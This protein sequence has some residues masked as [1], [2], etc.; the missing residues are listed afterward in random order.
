MKKRYKMLKQIQ[1]IIIPM[2]MIMPYHLVQAEDPRRSGLSSEVLDKA[3][4][5]QLP[6]GMKLPSHLDESIPNKIELKPNEYTSQFLKYFHIEIQSHTALTNN[7]RKALD[8]TRSYFGLTIGN[9]IN[10]VLSDP[11]VYSKD[12]KFYIGLNV[13]AS[14]APVMLKNSVKKEVKHEVM[15]KVREGAST[16]AAAKVLQAFEAQVKPGIGAGLITEAEYQAMLY[17]NVEQTVQAVSNNES[18]IKSLAH[19]HI[20]KMD[21]RI[22]TIAR[23]TILQQL[24]VKFAWLPSDNHN[25]II[26]GTVGKDQV[27]GNFDQGLKALTTFGGWANIAN[28]TQGTGVAHLG[29]TTALSDNMKVSFE[30]WVFHDRA[31][32]RGAQSLVYNVTTMSEMEYQNQKDFMELD[33]NMQRI[34]IEFPSPHLDVDTKNR[35]NNVYLTTGN[36]NGSRAFGGGAIFQITPRISVQV[37]GITGRSE[38]LEYA[39]MQSL[40]FEVNSDLTLYISNENVKGLKSSYHLDDSTQSANV[41]RVAVG[42]AYKLLSGKIKWINYALNIVASLGYLYEKSGLYGDQRLDVSGGAQLLIQF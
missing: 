7:E 10:D 30:S 6:D 17:K 34:S 13:K 2:A 28:T 3:M 39:L 14:L 25:V 26:F 4:R 23:E 36:F 31:P 35:K 38:L 11:E 12:Q 21:K 27:N 5:P 20:Q 32:F 33:S 41:G 15:E 24:S 1:S 9:K 18:L 22:D 19:S 42:G 40:M 16:A 8:I 37:E 29:V